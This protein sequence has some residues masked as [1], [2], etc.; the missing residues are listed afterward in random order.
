[1]QRIDGL[2][3]NEN[4]VERVLVLSF[5]LIC[6]GCASLPAKSP[7]SEDIAEQRKSRQ[8]KVVAEFAT[9]RD[10]A[11]LKAAM[12]RWTE[13]DEE[14]CE[15]S[16]R[17]LLTRNPRNKDAG[18]ALADL[19]THKEDW[20]AAEELFRRL[21]ADL[22]DPQ[23]HHSLALLL[24]ATDRCN[25]AVFHF[26]RAVELEPQNELYAL[27]LEAMFEP[28]VLPDI[29]EQTERRDAG[30]HTQVIRVSD[31]VQP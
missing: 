10:E 12:A 31:Q 8:Q 7:V 30:A 17:Q 28:P 1:M 22:D 13:G 6:G 23:I 2:F 29:V 14:G 27:S 20:K 19:L 3:G 26:Q 24:D 18:I 4:C 11:Q 9:R 5:A 21:L 16:L 15:T 25:E